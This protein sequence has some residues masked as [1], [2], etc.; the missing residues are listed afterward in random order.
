[1]RHSSV[2]LP[3][4]AYH[5]YI[6]ACSIIARCPPHPL[7]VYHARHALYRSLVAGRM[8]HSGICISS[9]VSLWTPIDPWYP[10]GPPLVRGIPVDPHWSVVFLWTPIGPWYPCGPP[11]GPRCPPFKPMGPDHDGALMGYVCCLC[12]PP[13]PPHTH[14]GNQIKYRFSSPEL[15]RPEVDVSFLSAR[16]LPP[17][18]SI[19]FTKAPHA[20]QQRKATWQLERPCLLCKIQATARPPRICRYAMNA[21]RL[22]PDILDTSLLSGTKRY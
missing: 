5:R 8:G 13:P 22:L 4:S 18:A 14:V 19:A 9:M 20:P 6:L 12:A 2:W 21:T 10:C 3:P 11:L 15:V 17:G 16:H 1:M 7:K